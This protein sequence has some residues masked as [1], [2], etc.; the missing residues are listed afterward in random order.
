MRLSTTPRIDTA[1]HGSHSGDLFWGHGWEGGD[2]PFPVP[3]RLR[4][5]TRVPCFLVIV[6]S[7]LLRRVEWVGRWVSRRGRHPRP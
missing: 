6:A 3:V 5:N 1:Q 2:R 4:V 7:W